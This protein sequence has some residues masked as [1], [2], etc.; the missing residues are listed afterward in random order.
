[1]NRFTSRKFL[2]A[3]ASL[4]SA[5]WALAESLITGDQYTRVIIATVAAYIVG[6]VAQKAT[7]KP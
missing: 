1:M 3:I 6:N 2:A 7:A 5:H 4:I